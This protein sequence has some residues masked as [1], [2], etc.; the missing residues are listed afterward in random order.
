M[1][2]GPRSPVDSTQE[3]GSVDFGAVSGK[4]CV[5]RDVA[6]VPGK[7][8]DN[9]LSVPGGFVSVTLDARGADFD[10]APFES[11][12]NTLRVAASP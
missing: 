6:P 3:V 5:Y 10:E 8:V 4:K 2:T 9:I 12:L 11:R 7:R 1:S